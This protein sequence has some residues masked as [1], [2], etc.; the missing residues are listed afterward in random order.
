MGRGGSGQWQRPKD[1]VFSQLELRPS[2]ATIVAEDEVSSDDVQKSS[3]ETSIF[4][5]MYSS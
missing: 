5:R 3:A 2:G 4:P 1:G